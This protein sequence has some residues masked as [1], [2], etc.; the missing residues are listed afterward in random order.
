MIK[1]TNINIYLKFRMF[2]IVFNYL[3]FYKARKIL[4]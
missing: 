4:F 2:N 1:I 3:N